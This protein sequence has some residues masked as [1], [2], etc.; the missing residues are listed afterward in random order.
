MTQLE[1]MGAAANRFLSS[2]N[3]WVFPEFSQFIYQKK[4]IILENNVDFSYA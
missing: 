4:E 2:R 1:A 3:R